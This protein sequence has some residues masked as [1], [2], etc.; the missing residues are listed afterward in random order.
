MT[1][2]AWLLPIERL[3]LL[4]FVLL[5][6]F[7]GAQAWLYQRI[8]VG[9]LMLDVIVLLI[10]AGWTCLA[11]VEAFRRYDTVMVRL[12]AAAAIPL[13]GVAAFLL[14]PLAARGAAHVYLLQHQA[15]LG[16]IRRKAPPGA[17]IAFPYLEGIPDGGV[18]IIDSPRGRPEALAQRVQL[19]LT[20][21]RITGCSTLRGTIYLCNFD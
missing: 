13:A 16:A 19:E 18:A 14:A 12:R 10:V 6:L 7:A 3:A 5:F 21:E 15:E 20:G 1:R 4:L 8:W 11:V 17:A 9:V 2:Q